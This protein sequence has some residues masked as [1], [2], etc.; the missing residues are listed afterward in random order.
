MWNKYVIAIMVVVAAIIG[1]F[2]GDLRGQT[3]SIVAAD[4]VRVLVARLDLEKY[5]ATVRD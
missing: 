1:I 5:K 2:A 3:F 4:P